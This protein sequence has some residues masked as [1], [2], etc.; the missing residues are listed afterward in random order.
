METR[1]QIPP[2]VPRGANPE[3]RRAS[4]RRPMRG[5]QASD[6]L[7]AFTLFLGGGDGRDD[8]RAPGVEIAPRAHRYATLNVVGERQ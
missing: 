2:R 7:E 8:D 6:R 5:R 1:G 4:R 3:R